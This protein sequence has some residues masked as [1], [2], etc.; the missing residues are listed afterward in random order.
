LWLT[1]V[2]DEDM[3]RGD[4]IAFV[5]FA[6][7]LLRITKDSIG[8]PSGSLLVLRPWQIDLV[9]RLLA[10]RPDGRLKHRQALIGMPRKQ[11]KSALSAG[12]ALYGLAFGPNGGEVYSIAADKDQAR[13]VFGTAK[14]MVELEPQFNGFFKIYRD[15]IEMPSTGSV[16]RVLSSEAFTKEGLN[17]HLTVADEVHAQP[18]RELWDTLSL[19]SGARVEPLMVGITTAG[20]KSDSS[21]RDS[22]C[23]SMYQH[24]C[25]VV[26]REIKDPAFFFAW[27]GAPDG[28]DHRD[29]NVWHGA[30]PGLGDIVSV[31]DFESSILRTPENEFRT[32]RLDQ[33]VSAVQAWL[34]AGAW[35]SCAD[36]SAAIEDGAEVCLGFDGSFNNDSTALVVVSTVSEDRPIP[37]VDVVDA[38]E[39]PEEAAEEW[40]VPILDVEEAIRIA[41]RRWKVREI[42]C[43]PARW[44]R[45]Y[46]ILEDEGLPIV[47]F[48]QSPARMTP[49]TA[50]FYE[51]VANKT[52]TQSGDPRLSRHMAN[53]RTRTDNRGTRISKDAKSSP[54]K[55]DLAVAAV[56]ALE[57]ACQPPPKQS[58]AEYFVWA[59]L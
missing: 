5:G 44:A 15:A 49:A 43:D 18:N 42:V 7:Q 45:T 1:D 40:T 20:V 12:I 28:A 19:A 4:G 52:L 51:S 10:R 29:R 9:K 32:K 55:I 30:N 57:R 14:K 21:G 13:I 25:R 46:Q 54:R 58:G 22:L 16:Y 35:E 27:W 47:E 36:E 24:G 6:Q 37:H 11:G 23:Y 31:E 3:A 2:S 33:W 34:P 59:D 38:W 53:C 56:M 41:C 26:K 39:R 17:P 50:R 8:G 48:P